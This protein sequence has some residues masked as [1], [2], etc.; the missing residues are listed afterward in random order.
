MDEGGPLPRDEKSTS[1]KSLCK[2]SVFSG[3]S[4]VLLNNYSSK[5][6]AM[7]GSQSSNFEQGEDEIAGIE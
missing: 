6:S 5:R 2:N 4:A 1:E 7:A 3:K